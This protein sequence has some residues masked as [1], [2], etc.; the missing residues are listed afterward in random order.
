MKNARFLAY[1]NDSIVTITLKPGQTLRWHESHQED[2]GWSYYQI[3]WTHDG[4]YITREVN[5]GGTDCDGRIDYSHDDV[6]HI[7]E[8]TARYN[9]YRNVNMPEWVETDYEINDHQARA[10]NY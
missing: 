5:S 3:V 7:D 2:E 9:D 8:L 4:D 10:A 6:C 1:V